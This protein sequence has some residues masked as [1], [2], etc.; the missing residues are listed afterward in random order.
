MRLQRDEAATAAVIT[1]ASN[2]DYSVCVCMLCVVIERV[3]ANA[4]PTATVYIIYT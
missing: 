4:N 1:A 2:E 3:S